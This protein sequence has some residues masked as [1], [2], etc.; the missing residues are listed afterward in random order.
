MPIYCTFLSPSSSALRSGLLAVLQQSEHMG[1]CRLAC[2]RLPGALLYLYDLQV[3]A[4]K[5]GV[6]E[7]EERDG[8][9][10]LKL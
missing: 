7:G 3:S 4:G 9:M 6:R 10:E 1:P 2:P 8:E 5:G